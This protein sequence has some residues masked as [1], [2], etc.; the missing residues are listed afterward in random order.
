MKTAPTPSEELRP[1]RVKRRVRSNP[2]HFS[3]PCKAFYDALPHAWRT[4][5]SP[6]LQFATMQQIDP[7]TIDDAVIALYRAQMVEWTIQDPDSVI[8]CLIK[9]WN[10]LRAFP[11]FA[12]L[13]S[14]SVRP[15]LRQQASERRSAL[16]QPPIRDE[17]DRLYGRRH[18]RE[19][20]QAHNAYNE[21]KRMERLVEA[22]SL[23]GHTIGCIADLA[24]RQVLKDATDRL[25]AG[26][27]RSKARD[28]VL[29]TL[30][31]ALRNGA[32]TA[33]L[34]ET[35]LAF[36]FEFEQA[37]ISAPAKTARTI[38]A[39]DMQAIV[40]LLDAS[41]AALHEALSGKVG[42]DELARS[43]AAIATALILWNL[44]PR[45][46]IEVAEFTPKQGY[47]RPQLHAMHGADVIDLE[48]NLPESLS[49]GID[50][51][52]AVMTARIGRP[53]THLLDSGRKSPVSGSSLSTGVTRL[54]ASM[55]YPDLNP[56]LLR[57]GA[58]A[59]ALAE[60]DD[61]ITSLA[62]ANGYRYAANFRMRY[63]GL[64]FSKAS[65]RVE[66]SLYPKTP[67]LE[68]RGSRA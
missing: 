12:S 2:N 61:I 33:E 13:N 36:R 52:H 44:C 32:Q 30:E 1:A 66:S 28:L 50:R 54:L 19:G 56:G 29:L 60:G 22:A 7:S 21:R 42:Y 3:A 4:Y 14:L 23:C 63:R 18:P 57:D 64:I 40:A 47:G 39:F 31:R 59:A 11:S 68:P 53:P 65:H 34:Q 17:F 9:D 35:V 37:G 49:N 46:T 15:R 43:R 10:T 55:G 24:N 27:E 26:C 5:I 25:Y 41:A 6:L 48:A 51:Y 8:A 20:V 67:E 16:L 38:A 58:N 62:E 45:R